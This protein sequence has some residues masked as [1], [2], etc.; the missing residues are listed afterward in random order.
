MTTCLIRVHQAH[1]SQPYVRD[2]VISY[3]NKQRITSQVEPSLNFFFRSS[4]LSRSKG[5]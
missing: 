3:Q 4:S 2:I 5:P 1:A